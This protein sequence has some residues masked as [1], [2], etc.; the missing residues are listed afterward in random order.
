MDAQDEHKLSAT[1]MEIV[2]ALAVAGGGDAVGNTAQSF[3]GY[4]M[5]S[6]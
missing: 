3:N 6:I 1:I 2:L 5:V 4:N